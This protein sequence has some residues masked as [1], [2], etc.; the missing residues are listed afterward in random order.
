MPV[1]ILDALRARLSP[2][3]VRFTAG[4]GRRVISNEPLDSSAWEGLRGEYFDN[5]DFAGP[6]R[7]VRADA[8]LDFAWT[9]GSPAE[10]IGRDGFSVRWTG[11]LTVPRGR[12]RRLGV[13][14][15][16][17]YR[18]WVDGR[19]ALDNPRS[20]SFGV[21]Y[22][23]LVLQPGQAHDVRVDYRVPVGNGRIRL[24]WDAAGPFRVQVQEA[25]RLASET[26]ATI[27]VAGL[28]EG[29]FRDRASLAL[30]GAQ[31][32]LIEEVAKLGK[33]LVVVIVGG[34]AV[35]MPWLDRVGAV[36]M[37]WYPGEAG[38]EAVADAL[39]GAMNPAGRL[40]ITFPMSEGQLPLYYNHKPTGRGDDYLD[41]SGLPLFPFG[42]GLS[43][44]TF[45]YS[46]LSIDGD[47]SAGFTVLA[48]VTNTGSRAG[49]EVVQLYL[50]DELASVARPV[51]QLAGF[52]RIS[53]AP[54]QS[55][56]VEFQVTRDQ[57]SLLDEKLNTVVE[58]GGWRVMVGSSSRDIRLIGKYTVR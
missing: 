38:G 57:L 53:L 55:G 12:V 56:T 41:L 26:S 34:S 33:P 25:S 18:L 50:R 32:E 13:E 5:P 22:T 1:S 39:L 45:E 3:R 6:P 7:L 48:R 20:M 10:G 31:Q 47:G 44:T 2:D 14:A 11:K 35:T 51:M 43:Y 24:V 27:I 9:L 21:K 29:E 54:G 37:A 16:D 58:P 30:P 36:L 15:N 28:E 49:D 42:Y 40:P 19:L 8:R 17:G 52:E 46:G 23:E 4:P